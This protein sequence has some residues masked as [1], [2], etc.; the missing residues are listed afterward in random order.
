MFVLGLAVS[1]FPAAEY[2]RRGLEFAN[3]AR[4]ISADAISVL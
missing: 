4:G 2:T 3:V 1:R